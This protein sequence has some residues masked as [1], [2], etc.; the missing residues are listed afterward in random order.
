MMRFGENE[1]HILAK[2][3]VNGLVQKAD[4]MPLEELPSPLHKRFHG[5]KSKAL[6]YFR[7]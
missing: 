2:N 7:T 6:V 1:V 5:D 3:E 4:L